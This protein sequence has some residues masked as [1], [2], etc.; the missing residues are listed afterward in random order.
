MRKIILELQQQEPILTRDGGLS[1]ERWTLFATKVAQCMSLAA[2]VSYGD[3]GRGEGG[4]G[5]RSSV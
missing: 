2:E 3:G 4:G 1:A 5:G